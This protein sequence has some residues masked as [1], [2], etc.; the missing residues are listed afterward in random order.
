MANS[1]QIANS[2]NSAVEQTKAAIRTI[3]GQDVILA[4]DVARIY[5]ETTKR[6]NER[7]RRHPG[8]FPPDFMFQLTKSEF[9][10]LRSQSA[11]SK[12]GRGGTQYMPYAFTEH[13]VLQIANLINT[14]MADSVS[15][16]V[17]RA[18]VEMRRT[19]I[20][21]QKALASSKALVS[22][23][24]AGSKT[25]KAETLHKE[26][27]PKLQTTIYRILDSVIG[28]ETGTTVKDEAL[29]I[30]KES[31]NHLKEQLRHKGLQNEEITA[32]VTKL[33]AEAENQRAAARKTRAESEQLEFM[34]TIR[35]LRLVLEAQLIMI[36]DENTKDAQRLNGLVEVLRDVAKLS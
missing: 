23:K 28:T 6:I 12:V 22:A 36:A 5:G 34:N 1:D 11:T 20:A 35:K 3:R 17:I 19:I 27:I 24:S 10:E 29:D 32:R 14:D 4:S 15:V 9:D 13:G 16:F 25:P 18:F 26:L 30:L 2:G 31:I 8:K 21:Q 7:A 33:L